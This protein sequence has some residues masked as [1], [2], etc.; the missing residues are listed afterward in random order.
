MIFQIL[1]VYI[2]YVPHYCSTTIIANS[3]QLQIELFPEG[4]LL[5]HTNAS[6]LNYPNDKI[7]QVIA[8]RDHLYILSTDSVVQIYN[9]NNPSIL[10]G[11][12]NDYFSSL[13]QTSLSIS[14]M[15]MDANFDYLTLTGFSNFILTHI[16]YST[17]N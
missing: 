8:S 4:T 1:L 7:R 6:S 14:F 16:I 11:A 9:K 5:P 3:T 2:I 12:I 17:A 13:G 10:E 15:N